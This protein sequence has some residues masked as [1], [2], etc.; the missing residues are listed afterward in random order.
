M[1]AQSWCGLLLSL[2][3]TRGRSQEQPFAALARHRVGAAVDT[4][5]R[6]TQVPGEAP[7]D[8]G[9]PY[10]RIVEATGR[11]GYE[12]RNEYF[13]S[14]GKRETVQITRTTADFAVRY[15]RVQASADSAALAVHDGMASA[16]VAT[17]RGTRLI[18]V[19]SAPER[20]AG[21]LVEQALALSGPRVGRFVT[22]PIGNLYGPDAIGVSTDTL[23]V[24]ERTEVVVRGRRVPVL[25]ATHRNGNTS[26][27]DA[28]SGRIL[29]RRGRAGP[30]RFWWHVA[31]GVELPKS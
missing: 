16:W 5:D 3:A 29:A 2:W 1:R 26:W 4:L 20:Y 8:C 27:I 10:V 18:G 23:R 25:V 12:L 14:T 13:D 22:F 19:A 30:N 6:C 15:E 17:P 31:H 21:D 24:A 9:N 7:R 11:G 28:R